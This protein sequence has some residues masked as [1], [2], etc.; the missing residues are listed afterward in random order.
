MGIQ[1][2]EWDLNRRKNK[3][4]KRIFCLVLLLYSYLSYS[5]DLFAQNLEK[6]HARHEFEKEFL[7]QDRNFYEIKKAA[8]DYYKDRDRGKGSGYKQYKRW[9]W[10]M[11]PRVYPSGDRNLLSNNHMLKEVKIFENE[12]RQLK[13]ASII[14]W[15]S[16]GQE[17]HDNVNGHYSPGIGR[18]DRLAIDPNNN[19]IM[20][21]GAP[22]GGLWK[23]ED[24]GF[25]WFPVMDNIPVIG[26]SGIAINP[27]NSNE[28]YVSTGD[29]DGART[30]S[31]GIFKSIDAGISWNAIGLNHSSLD[32]VQGKDLILNPDD[33]NTLLVST[34]KGIHR[35]QDGGVTWT[36][37]AYEAFDDLAFKPGDPNT[38]Y[39][40]TTSGFYRSTDG[41]LSF[42]KRFDVEK[43]RLLIGVSPA[44]PDYVYLCSAGEQK[45][46]LSRSSGLNFAGTGN[47]PN[48]G[49]SG[50]YMWAFAV[51]DS[52]IDELHFGKFE[53]WKSVNQGATWTK[54]SNWYW[55]PGDIDY[56]HCDFHDLVFENNTLWACTDGGIAKSTNHGETWEL[57]FNTL[58]TTQIY[59]MNVCKS[60]PDLY[61]NGSQDNG[62]YYHED[63]IWWGWM[64]AD[65]M[66]CVWDYENKERIY[67]SIQNGVFHC[68]T[69]SIVQPGEGAWVTPLVIHPTNP[70]TLFVG[71]GVVNK[72]I[73]KMLSWTT[74][75]SFGSGDIRSLTIAESNPDYIFASKKARLWRTKDGGKTWNEITAGLPNL[76]IKGIAVH[77]KNHNLLAV[78]FSGYT[79]SKKVY[80]SHDAGNNWENLSLN[81]PNI[82]ANCV[83]FDDNSI[84][85]I[86][87][88]MDVGVYY[89]DTTSTDWTMYSEGLPNVIVTDLEIHCDSDQLFAGTYGRGMWKTT[90]HENGNLAPVSNFL[91]DDTI[92][93]RDH[94]IQFR[95]QSF[96]GTTAWNWT[97]EGATPFSSTLKNPVVTYKD[98]GDYDIS[99]IAMNEYGADTVKISE[100][101]TIAEGFP[102]EVDFSSSLTTIGE[103]G[104]TQFT[105]RS[106]NDPSNWEWTFEA[107]NPASSTENNPKVEYSTPGFYN[108]TLTASN[109]HGNDTRTETDFI[110]VVNPG[111]IL[112]I[113]SPVA[114]G[115]DDVEEKVDGSL[116]TTSS[117]LELIYDHQNQSVGIR[118][119]NLQI[120]QGAKIRKAYI[121]FKAKTSNSEDLTLYIHGQDIGN[122]PEFD[123]KKA[124]EVS[125]RVKTSGKVTWTPGSWIEGRS[126]LPEQ[127]PSLVDIVQ[128]I[129]VKSD[130]EPGNALTMIITG[131]GTNQ[132]KAYSY[133]GGHPAILVIEYEAGSN[134]TSVP[135]VNAFTT[136]QLILHEA[137]PNPFSEN[138]SIS[139]YLPENS[140]VKL[141]VYNLSGQQVKILTNAVHHKAGLHKYSWDGTDNNK[142]IV[143]NGIYIIKIQ[144]GHI[145]AGK[146]ISFIK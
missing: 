73:D 83:V 64:G 128:S 124:H 89:Y 36:Q 130:W 88:G 9:E 108:V 67:G 3:Q 11:E 38:V 118:F 131:S 99:L 90:S 142:K 5:P 117:D 31:A 1:E 66:D 112:N 71:N 10:F 127:T 51:S 6:N 72:T 132:R 92:A 8:E 121:Q 12:S 97:F 40:T 59:K 27:Q 62:T 74:I 68:S 81:L 116:S 50:W 94:S 129:I 57:R 100:Y 84:E 111:T 44:S 32:R 106:T 7:D 63:N 17:T 46:Y 125:G 146:K 14:E 77:P 61:L 16:L 96:N 93:L 123:D 25:N 33:P 103:G 55:K 98:T 53:S 41:G 52:N 22:T 91:A 109:A 145:H 144:A 114:T 20:Y 137:Y 34:S 138:T 110:R 115:I 79:Q 107:G 47:L 113:Y 15:I 134:I 56:T 35:T 13:T 122:S 136:N 29:A 19:D 76:F 26:V 95:D 87:V 139:F 21:T 43:G 105:D 60:D 58:G 85:S 48:P 143:A 140:P 4:V 133:D 28:I 45:I 39:A 75:G 54:T 49:G 69:H 30:Y 65:G 80:I 119:R 102:P 2:T 70:S 120:P 23:T 78:S 141:S 135:K 37:V 42:E 126:N 104:T 101:I 18:M 82:P 86:Y 24:G